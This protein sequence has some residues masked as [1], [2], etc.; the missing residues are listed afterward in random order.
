MENKNADTL[1]IGTWERPVV[2]SE[3]GPLRSV[4]VF[5]ENHHLRIEMFF[6]S[7]TEPMVLEGSYSIKDNH[8]ITEQM[9]KG[10]PVPFE[11]KFENKVLLL[12]LPNEEPSEFIR[13]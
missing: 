11:F 9:H 10:K 5:D 12:H 13:Q 1:I 7:S 4:L 6:G 8:L 2:E 3:W